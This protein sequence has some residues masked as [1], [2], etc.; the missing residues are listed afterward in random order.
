MSFGDLKVQDLIYEDASNNEITVVIADL[1]TKANPTFTGTVTVPTATAGDNSTKAASTAFVVA[2]FA[3]KA[4]PAFTGNATGVNLTLSGDLTVNG[5]TTTINTTTL[6][7][8]DK[9]I[10]IGKVSSPSDTTADGGGLTLLGATNKTWNWVNSTDAWTSSEHI[11]IASGKS[12]RVNGNNVLSQTTLGSTVVSSSL[13]SLGTLTG[14]TVNGDVTLTGAAN[15]V[16]WDKSDNALEFADNAK[17]TFGTGGDLSIYHN[18]SHTYIDENGTGIFAIRS[19]GTEIALTSVSGESM[20]RFINDGAVELYHDNSKKLETSSSGVTVTGTLAATAVTGDGSGLSNLPRGNTVDL[21]ADGAI[22]AGKPV[23]IKSNGKAQQVQ[24]TGTP[25][26][27]VVA[28]GE[29][30]NVDTDTNLKEVQSLWMEQHRMLTIF[31][32]NSSDFLYARTYKF[33]SNWGITTGSTQTLASNTCRNVQVSYDAQQDRV[34]VACVVVRSGNYHLEAMVGTPSTSNTNIGSW[35]NFVD[36]RIETGSGNSNEPLALLY[37]STS[38][39]HVLIYRKIASGSDWDVHS[40]V[41][42]LSGNT[43]TTNSATTFDADDMRYFDIC[44]VDASKV[45]ACGRQNS[46]GNSGTGWARIGTIGSTT[47]TWGSRVDF[48]GSGSSTISYDPERPTSIVYDTANS[49]LF[50][51][52]IHQSNKR[53]YSVVGSVSG[54]TLSMDT[55]SWLDLTGGSNGNSESW[56]RLVRDPFGG[57]I[58]GYWTQGN[59]SDRV[60]AAKITYDNSAAAKS[61]RGSTTELH[62]SIQDQNS[63]KNISAVGSGRIYLVAN[64]TSSSDHFDIYYSSVGNSS[65]NQTNA[66]FLGFAQS[67]ISDTNSGTIQT[68]GS[69]SENQSGLTPASR[70]YVKDDGTLTTD[71]S[72]STSKGGGLAIA[73]DKLIIDTIGYV[74]TTYN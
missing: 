41:I 30:A 27:T 55:S 42:S 43:F 50:V 3:P 34:M 15:N 11:E 64:D 5:T 31:W 69:V 48:T 29:I 53:A 59:A 16:V 66:N 65:T 26:S 56:M 36:N 10:E 39:K 25:R 21:V 32:T 61:T 47:M 46:G 52:W 14:L 2:S 38:Q 73:S 24:V 23:I 49:K 33:A 1:A 45:A 71:R 8:E 40:R 13:T 28:L 68:A 35:T 54:T 4:A 37:E 62:N 57:G 44:R 17:A 7:V 70:Y 74:G 9:N 20:G 72:Q 19:N 12:F 58:Y 67:A 51:G 22:A 63:N 60:H 18:G 6:Q